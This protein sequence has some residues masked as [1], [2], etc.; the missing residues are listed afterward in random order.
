MA[1]TEITADGR[2]ADEGIRQHAAE[3]AV[4]EVLE[5]DPTREQQHAVDDRGSAADRRDEDHHQRWDAEN[6]RCGREETADHDA[7]DRPKDA[8]VDP[9]PRHQPDA[10]RVPERPDRDGHRGV[11]PEVRDDRECQPDGDPDDP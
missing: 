4:L 9:E 7:D 2:D 5:L 1:K 3:Q 10:E 6:E 11:V 8:G